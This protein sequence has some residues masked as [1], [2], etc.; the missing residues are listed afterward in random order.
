MTPR[1]LISIALTLGLTALIA[2]GAL[3]AVPPIPKLFDQ[4]DKLEH[5]LAFGALTLWLIV[6]FGPRN[7]IFCA[8]FAAAGA[9]A[10]ELSQHFFA[11]GREGSFFDG[12]ASLTG[13]VLAVVFVKTVRYLIRSKGQDC[14]SEFG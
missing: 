11:T 6:M 4:Q 5:I 2:W 8:A 14:R 10:L 13:I 3:R 12:L 1:R 9:V 7:M